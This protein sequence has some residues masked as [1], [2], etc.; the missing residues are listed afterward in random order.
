MVQREY[1]GNFYRT[2]SLVELLSLVHIRHQLKQEEKFYIEDQTMVSTYQGHTVFSIFQ[3]C[4]QV[5][6]Q[7]LQQLK[8][9][10]F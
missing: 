2:Y 5:Y 9:R 6:D 10:N 8:H 7:I 1:E 3:F 4:P